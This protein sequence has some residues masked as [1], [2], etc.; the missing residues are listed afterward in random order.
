MESYTHSLL[1]RR[2]MNVKELFNNRILSKELL[3]DIIEL[4]IRGYGYTE[5]AKR[6]K[7]SRTTAVKYSFALR[8]MTKEELR[9]VLNI[10]VKRLK[11]KKK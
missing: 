3:L 7:V 4:K 5:I 10:M 8:M 6:L 2:K 9:L 1:G 11:E